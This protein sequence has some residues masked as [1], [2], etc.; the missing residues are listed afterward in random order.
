MGVMRECKRG[1]SSEID[2]PH[3]FNCFIYFSIY[4]VL[5]LEYLKYLPEY[6]HRLSSTKGHCYR[7]F[8]A[9]TPITKRHFSASSDD[10]QILKKDLDS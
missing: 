5:T 9:N 2:E 7:V 10:N 6:M 1:L 8:H 3:S 4:P